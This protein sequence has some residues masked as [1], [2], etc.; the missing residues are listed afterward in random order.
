MRID[1]RHRMEGATTMKGQST[2]KG[3]NPSKK[4]G[5]AQNII[6]ILSV[7]ILLVLSSSL[8]TTAKDSMGFLIS[9]G[10]PRAVIVAGNGDFYRNYTNRIVGERALPQVLKAG[11]A[12]HRFCGPRLFGS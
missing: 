4:T 7:V 11:S 10:Q 3:K 6:R 2:R 1:L 12:D 5:A 8:S 9:Q